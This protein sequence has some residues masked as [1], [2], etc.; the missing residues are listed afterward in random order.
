MAS[1]AN[2]LA[3][4]ISRTGSNSTG[5]KVPIRSEGLRSRSPQPYRRDKNHGG[6]LPPGG[7]ERPHYFS[8]WPETQFRRVRQSVTLKSMGKGKIVYF[9]V[10]VFSTTGG[11]ATGLAYH[12]C[13]S[14]LRKPIVDSNFWSTFSQSLIS[15]ASIYCIIIPIL[16]RAQ[17]KTR[18]PWLFKG[19]LVLSVIA[20]VATTAIYPYSPPASL[21]FSYFSG[22]ALLAVTLQL[23]EVSSDK[24]EYLAD[25]LEFERYRNGR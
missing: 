11:V 9:I 22:I 25:E 8:K 1:S 23:I 18:F 15:C 10:L 20:G 12:K 21:V 13:N 3:P 7:R 6:V 17:I 24:I 19:L 16:R 4:G 5:L 2:G 14:D